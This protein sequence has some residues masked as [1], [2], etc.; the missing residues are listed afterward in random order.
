M[1]SPRAA[2]TECTDGLLIRSERHRKMALDEFV[3]HYN[4]RTAGSALR[5]QSPTRLRRSSPA[6]T[7]QRAARLGGFV[8]EY[9]VAA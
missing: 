5:S 3:E 7:V 8:N 9:P 4:E 2:R 1:R 6:L